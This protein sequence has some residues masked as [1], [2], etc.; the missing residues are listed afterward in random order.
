MIWKIL[1]RILNK[2]MKCDCCR[3]AEVLDTWWDK[4]RL[5]FFKRFKRDLEDFR[6]DFY[7]QGISEGY[8]LG[9]NQAIEYENA[10]KLAAEISVLHSEPRGDTELSD[11]EGRD[12][13]TGIFKQGT[14]I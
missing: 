8:K 6:M 10:K 3:Q 2:P 13:S 7:T 11:E 1:S 12:T 9:F 4:I 5:F 14:G